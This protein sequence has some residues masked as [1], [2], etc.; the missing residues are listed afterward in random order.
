MYYIY[1]LRSLRDNKKYTG[2]TSKSPYQRLEEHNQGSNKFTKENG[3]YELVYYEEYMCKQD[4]LKREGFYKSGI[5][6]KVRDAIIEAV[7]ARGGPAFPP[8][9]DMG[10]G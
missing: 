5:G 4:A 9:A 10:G 8:E 3:P 6:R 7:S 1:F 2:V